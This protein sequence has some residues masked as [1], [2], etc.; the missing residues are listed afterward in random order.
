LSEGFSSPARKD[1]FVDVLK[2]KG[3]W[4]DVSTFKGTINVAYLLKDVDKVDEA[5]QEAF[6][7]Y[8][9]QRNN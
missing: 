3:V 2:R 6:F 4:Y 9:E 1:V 7:I 8:Y 5:Y